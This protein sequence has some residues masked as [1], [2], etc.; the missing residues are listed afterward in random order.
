M[1]LNLHR[2]RTL[3]RLEQ[4]WAYHRGPE[5]THLKYIVIIFDKFTSQMN[6]DT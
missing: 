2:D 6:G 4:V 3:D 5:K 1:K